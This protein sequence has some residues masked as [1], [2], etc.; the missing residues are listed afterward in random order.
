MANVKSAGVRE[1]VLDRCLRKRR[2]YTVEELMEKVNETLMFEGL[3]VITSTNTIRNDL[4]NISN[5]WKKSLVKGKR[6]QAIVYAYEDPNFSIYNSQLT[7]EE[8]RQLHTVLMNAKFIDAY[9]GS[10]MYP[11]LCERLAGILEL[12]FYEQ[13]ILLYENVPTKKELQHLNMLYDCIQEKQVVFMKYYFEKRPRSDSI[14]PYFLR[15][16]KQQ[17]HLLGSESKEQ[18]AVNIPIKTVIS[19]DVDVGTE[20]IPNKIFDVEDYYKKLF[21][22]SSV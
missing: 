7:R 20:Y 6:R 4:T 18:K 10:I 13:P 9:Q 11:E 1:L 2:G 12:S 8:L 14:H 19:I 17:W 15:Q 22:K 3:P 21:K 5:R 16:N